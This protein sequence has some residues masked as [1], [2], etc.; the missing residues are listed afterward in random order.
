MCLFQELQKC[1]EEK[2]IPMLQE[3]LGKMP[4]EEA[5]MYLR[6]CIDSGLWIP[7]ANKA[8]AERREEAGVTEESE[9]D[10][11]DSLSEDSDK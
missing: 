2:D 3:V 1:F 10:Q 5:K 11:Y 4:E 6:Q 9:D 8:Q 7:D